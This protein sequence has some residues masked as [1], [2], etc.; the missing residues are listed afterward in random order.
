MCEGPG[1]VA[2]SPDGTL[3]YVCSSF[4][5]NFWVIHA[6]SKE[7]LKTL[8]VPSIFSPFVNVSQDG[9]QVWVTHKDKGMVTRIDTRNHTI[10]ESF[11][12]GAITN[13]VAF[14]GGHY[15]VSVGGE[16]KVKVYTLSDSNKAVLEKEI[17]VHTLPHGIWA[18]AEQKEIYV[19]AELS[20]T[21]HII[22]TENWQIKKTLP[23][24]SPMQA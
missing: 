1:M 3:A 17:P 23:A 19:V 18:N 15:Y 6:H 16:N 2:F 14:A 4:D 12:S 7:I 8:K 22:D 5:D 9:K 21:L 20:N 11:A 24:I 13:H 10:I